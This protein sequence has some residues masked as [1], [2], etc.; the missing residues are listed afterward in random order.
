MSGMCQSDPPGETRVLY[1]GNDGDGSTLP[2][3]CLFIFPPYLLSPCFV[4]FLLSDVEGQNQTQR[5]S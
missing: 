1:G 2:Q 3:V 4:Q 5:S